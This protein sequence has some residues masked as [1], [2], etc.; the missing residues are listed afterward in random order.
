MLI[1]EF[2]DNPVDNHLV[3]VITT[4]MGVTIGGHHLEHTVSNLQH[5][6]VGSTAT[7]IGHHN[8]LCLVSVDTIGKCGCGRFVDNPLHIETRNLA[9]ILH[10]LTGSVIIIGRTCDDSISHSLTKIVLR[11]LLHLLENHSGQFL[12]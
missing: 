1:L 4:K 7:D 5:S 8:L 3:E 2:L 6:E 9:G 12:R 10:S 11:S